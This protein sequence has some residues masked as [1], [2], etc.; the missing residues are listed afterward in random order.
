MKQPHS[1]QT[2]NLSNARTPAQRRAE[3]GWATRHGKI[4]R[5]FQLPHTQVLA[6]PRVAVADLPE[7][8]LKESHVEHLEHNQLIAS[9]C[10]HPENHEVEAFRSHPAESA[11]DIYVFYCQCG[12][13]HRF[14]CVGHTD[15]K[16]P[17]WDAS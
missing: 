9:C 7:G 10:R 5:G 3:G 2:I 4:E 6:C 1:L 11:P 12:R 14:L 17:A 13:K 15:E 16:R 8:F